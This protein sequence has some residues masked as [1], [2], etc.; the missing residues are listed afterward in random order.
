VDI[1]LVLAFGDDAERN[2]II[3]GLGRMWRY[4]DDF[5]AFQGFGS[6]LV[7]LIVEVKEGLKS[8]PGGVA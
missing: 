6:D 5:P 8:K 1:E 2:A 7:G 4:R 3:L